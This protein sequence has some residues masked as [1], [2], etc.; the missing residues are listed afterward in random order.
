VVERSVLE[1]LAAFESEKEDVLS[2]YL[3]VDPSKRYKDES[4]L[5]LRRLLA[6]IGD[7][8]PQD[9]ERV[10]KFLELEFDWQASG[11]AIFSSVANDFWR[12][13][14][15]HVP[16]SDVARVARRP[17]LRPLVN[18]IEAYGS[19]GV[20]LVDREQVR[21]MRAEQ[22]ELQESVELLG[23]EVRRHKQAD[24]RGG[25]VYQ[26]RAD[27]VALRNLREAAQ[28]VAHRCQRW[29]C[30]RLILGG[31]SENTHT[32]MDLLPK[33]VQQIVV[34]T[35]S[36]DAD[37]PEQDVLRRALEVIEKADQEKKSELVEA[38]ITTVEKGEGAALGMADVLALLQMQR[39]RTLIMDEAFSQPGYSC[40][41]CGLISSDSS[42][43]CRV[44]G[45]SM[46]FEP[47]AADAALRMALQQNVEL[48][49]VAGNERLREAGSIGAILRY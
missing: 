22:G 39:V 31:T 11:L 30:K 38:L 10:Q 29:H 47:D 17:M 6:D 28:T 44:C 26:R 7:T 33:H 13:Y 5:V 19:F 4:R 25:S 41:S 36:V 9:A 12:V 46:A 43:V 20:V 45:G 21:F 2:V 24:G 42:D 15:L 27:E 49:I 3:L 34:G 48:A 14:R 37:A 32:F 18:A 8:L 23:D 40:V 35:M 1:E 16:V